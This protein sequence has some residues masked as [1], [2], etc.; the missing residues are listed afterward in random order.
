MEVNATKPA[1]WV[2]ICIVAFALISGVGLALSSGVLLRMETVLW[3]D[4]NEVNESENAFALNYH[5]RADRFGSPRPN[6]D[7]MGS[8]KPN[9]R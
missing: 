4:N 8:P 2:L 7:D 9:K 6:G 5:M 1:T 3:K